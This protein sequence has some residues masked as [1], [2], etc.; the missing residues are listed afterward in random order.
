MHNGIHEKA[1]QGAA[2]LANDMHELLWCRQVCQNPAWLVQIPS[3]LPC[4]LFTWGYLHS[5]LLLSCCEQEPSL[6]LSSVAMRMQDQSGLCLQYF[7]L[8]AATTHTKLLLPVLTQKGKAF[9]KFSSVASTARPLVPDFRQARAADHHL[10]CLLL[11]H[12][13]T[14]PHMHVLSSWTHWRY[15]AA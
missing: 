8:L 5:R 11:Y 15:P 12:P 2:D 1:A 4:L 7:A 10:Q 6:A 9:P 14:V 3:Q 13:E